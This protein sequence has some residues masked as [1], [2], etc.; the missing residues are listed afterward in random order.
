MDERQIA[1]ETT[2]LFNEAAA[3][4]CK[5]TIL[6]TEQGLVAAQV[7]LD[8]FKRQTPAASVS[9][10]TYVPAQ[11]IPP[12]PAITLP[13]AMAEDTILIPKASW[14]GREQTVQTVPR[15][16]ASPDDIVIPKPTPVTS[17]DVIIIPRKG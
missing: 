3:V 11:P 7:K 12:A 8:A 1:Q 14:V 2:R 4:G 5:L 15:V 9:R 10:E 13:K 17:E 16:Q 6:G